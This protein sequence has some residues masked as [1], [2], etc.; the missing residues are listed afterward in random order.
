M[1]FVHAVDSFLGLGGTIGGILALPGSILIGEGDVEE[2]GGVGLPG[3][4]RGGSLRGCMGAWVMDLEPVGDSSSNRSTG[5]AFGMLVLI[6]EET[7][8]LSFVDVLERAE[9]LRGGGGSI[10]L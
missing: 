4:S 10:C 6:N 8:P 2:G 5:C 7:D 3:G 9:S 1:A